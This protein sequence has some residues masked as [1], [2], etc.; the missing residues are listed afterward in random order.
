ML[1]QQIHEEETLHGAP[2]FVIAQARTRFWI[3]GIRKL[4]KKIRSR[5]KFCKVVRSSPAHQP[6]APLPFTRFLAESREKQRA[7]TSV[8]IDYLGP[9]SPFK[10]ASK[11]KD[12]NYRFKDE[13]KERRSILVF[14]CPLTRA[15]HLELCEDQTLETFVLPYERFTATYQSPLIIHSDNQ[16]TFKSA[17]KGLHPLP[18]EVTDV[19]QNHTKGIKW[20]FNAPR[21]P[22]CSPAAEPSPSPSR[23][24]SAPGWRRG[25]GRPPRSG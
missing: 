23:R 16:S 1:V 20:M 4:A 21:A 25:S 10:Y 18:Q 22:W 7:F 5:C 11:N 15:V 13:P 2:E 17:S 19:L 14:S 12:P 3:V 24:T 9:F 6:E 8:G